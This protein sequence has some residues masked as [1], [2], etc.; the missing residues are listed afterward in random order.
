MR[1][2]KCGKNFDEK[3]YSGICPKCG[4][5]NNRQADYDVS[6]YFSAT[7][8]DSEKTSTK[9]QAAKQHEQLHKMYDSSNM[10]KAGAGSHEKLH[11]KYDKQ[12]MHSQGQRPLSGYQQAP[13]N[14]QGALPGKPN[15]YQNAQPVKS[16][17]PYQTGQNGTYGQN[18]TNTAGEAGTY[19]R[20]KY[21]KATAY[22]EEKKKNLVTP[23]CIAIAVLAIAG[24]AVGCHL[25][26]QSMEETY[27][28]L[29]FE[30]DTAQAGEVFEVNG[31]RI[32]VEKANVLDISAL[33][34]MPND[35]KLVAVTVEI[36]PADK[37]GN[38]GI[39][40]EVYVSDGSSYKLPLDV[41]TV[42]E[43]FYDGDY[44]MW[45][46]IFY[47]YDFLSDIP[48][49]GKTGNFYFLVDENAGDISITF[50]EGSEEDGIYAL[51]RRVSVPLQLEEDGK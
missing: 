28:T 8:D 3:M 23:I 30:Q 13:A 11:E 41:Y 24:T 40:G 47:R 32:I 37:S 1:C 46:D 38:N 12:N 21:G 16:G 42:M 49:D 4:Y 50:D 14:K 5:F 15:P 35:E 34:G 2:G 45:K 20:N 44:S 31:C 48:A 6:K 22:S 7:F 17:N 19:G 27:C 10:H 26:E 25:K 43:F 18:R 29:E 9:A 33:D 36:L 39:S 51:H